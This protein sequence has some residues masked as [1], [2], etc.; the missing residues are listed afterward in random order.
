MNTRLLPVLAA[1]SIFAGR[2]H[3]GAGGTFAPGGPV[4]I[5]VGLVA[6]AIIVL[7]V[8]RARRK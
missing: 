8:I 3:A 4:S 7:V 6:I 1:L 5:I 2:A